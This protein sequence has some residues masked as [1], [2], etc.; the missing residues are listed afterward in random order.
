MHLASALAEISKDLCRKRLDGGALLPGVQRQARFAAGLL[1][2]GHA[3][4]VM[5]YRN[6][7]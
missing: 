3:I 1:E 2:E 4:P 6:L 7:R 5:F